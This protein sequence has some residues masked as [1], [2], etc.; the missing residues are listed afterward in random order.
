MHPCMFSTSGKFTCSVLHLCVQ[1][2]TWS[3]LDCEVQRGQLFL[4][5]IL[6]GEEFSI[7]PETLSTQSVLEVEILL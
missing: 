3:G 1:T 6:H 7:N 5:F 4:N 2:S